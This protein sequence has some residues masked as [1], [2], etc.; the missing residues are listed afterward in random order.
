MKNETEINTV[1]EFASRFSLKLCSR[2]DFLEG[3][4]AIEK[5]AV[6]GYSQFT[7]CYRKRQTLL[8]LLQTLLKLQLWSR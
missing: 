6:G 2:L 7:E 5:D 8:L 3:V 4:L 1:N